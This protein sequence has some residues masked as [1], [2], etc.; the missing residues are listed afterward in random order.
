MCRVAWESI[1]RKGLWFIAAVALCVFSVS[2]AQDQS[3][4]PGDR[5]ARPDSGPGSRPDGA[6]RPDARPP[7]R[8]PPASRPPVSRPPVGGPRPPAVRPRPPHRFMSEGRWHQGIHGPAFR[9][10]PGYGYRRWTTGLILPPIL[11]TPPYYY[12]AYAPLGLGPPPIGY[13]WVRYGPD[14]LLVNIVSGRIADVVD[15][16]FY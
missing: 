14:L 11:L 16:V 8:P 9:Y 12:D 15:G 1:M 2:M 5:A 6:S 10:P 4:R 7:S 13:R 3:G